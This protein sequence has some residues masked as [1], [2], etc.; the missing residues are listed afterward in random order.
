MKNRPFATWKFNFANR[1]LI[2]GDKFVYK[3]WC[4]IQ[5]NGRLFDGHLDLYALPAQVIG[6]PGSI[7]AFILHIST[8]AQVP[9]P[10]RAQHY[11]LRRLLQLRERVI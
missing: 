10:Y 9:A 7:S 2:C 11:G 3:S 5:I 6:Y 4:D 8:G 1:D